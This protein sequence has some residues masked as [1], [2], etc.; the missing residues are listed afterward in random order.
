MSVLSALAAPPETIRV[1]HADDEPDLG[2]LTATFLEREDDRFAVETVTNAADGLERLAEIDVDCIVSDYDM[3]GQNGIAF[4]EAVREDHPDLPFILFTGKGSEEVASDAISAGVTDYLQKGGGTD[5]YTVLAN[6]ITNAV[7]HHRSRRMV[8]RSER[9]L[10]EIID[11]LPPLLYVVDEDGRYLLANEALADFHDTTVENLEGANVADVLGDALAEEFHENLDAVLR[12][13]TMTRF[14]E[15]EVTN[16]RGD[17]RVFEP[18]LRPYDFGSTETRTALGIATDV[19]DRRERERKLERMHDRMELALEHTSSIIF[20]IDLD[21]GD[22][23]RHGAFEQFFDRP[24]EQAPTWEDH[25][26]Q[27]VHPDDRAS[28]RRF[29]RRLLDGERD[30]GEIEYRT[31][32]DAGGVRWIRDTVSV[33]REAATGPSQ[34]IGIARDVTEQKERE[35]ELR[36][37]E[38][39]YQAVFNDPNIL[40]G[41]IDT[42]G[43]VLDI[44]Q[45]AIDYVDATLEELTDVPFWETPWFDHSAAVRE[46]VRDWIDRAASGE[47]VE[48]EADLVRPNGDPYTIEGVF[49]PVTD[50]D[51]EVVSLLISDR[52]VTERK[53]REREL[54]RRTEELEELAE[55]LGE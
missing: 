29:Y 48:F 32:P 49:R 17:T 22:V 34:A 20:E 42:D 25:L 43:T 23:I 26:E 55:R 41:L 8:E 53:Q 9:R 31:H 5:Q 30:G 24:A 15:I 12:E 7:E 19:T 47:Y 28:F 45:T 4:L 1:L 16:S 36:R 37:K 52:D 40:V 10:R 18:R 39:R 13:G 14:A 33:E 51:G 27:M 3:P 38:R 21:T 44:N 6:R 11:A 2:D 54:E 46:E 35:L 50:D